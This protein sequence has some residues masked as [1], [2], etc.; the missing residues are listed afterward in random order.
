MSND[1]D[2]DVLT[3]R[4]NKDLRKDLR[5]KNYKKLKK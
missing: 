5:D 1:D 3:S 2:D 4:A